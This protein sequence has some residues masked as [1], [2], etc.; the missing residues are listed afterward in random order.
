LTGITGIKLIAGYDFK[1]R[2]FLSNK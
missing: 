2:D 1:P